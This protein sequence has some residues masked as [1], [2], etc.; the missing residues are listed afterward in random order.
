MSRLFTAQAGSADIAAQFGVADAP[1]VPVPPE[2]V[3][4]D[5]GLIVIERDGRRQL[6]AAQWGFP[7]RRREACVEDQAPDI[8]GLVADLTN[9]MWENLVVE[10]AARCL[11]PLTHFANPAGEKGSKT[12]SWFSVSDRPIAAWA[13]FWNETDAYGPVFAGMTMTANDSVMPF[14]NR[15]PV[16]LEPHEYA[17]WLTGSIKDVITFQ[18]RRSLAA[19]RIKVFHSD[20]RWRSGLVPEFAAQGQMALL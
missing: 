13:G 9:P 8:I 15:M 11:I 19:N 7:R 6:K 5:Q 2:M 14:N 20:D 16:L 12:R 4:G 1:I 3:E 18:L 17:R 10:P